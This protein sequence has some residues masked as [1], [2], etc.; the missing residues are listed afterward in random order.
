MRFCSG[1]SA[2]QDHFVAVARPRKRNRHIHHS[3]G[4]A[5]LSVCLIRNDILYEADPAIAPGEVRDVNRIAGRYVPAFVDG[6]NV[7]NVRV[8]FDFPPEFFALIERSRF[9]VRVELFV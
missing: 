4:K 1:R 8:R 5:A 9:V 3:G 6:P 7:L 2:L